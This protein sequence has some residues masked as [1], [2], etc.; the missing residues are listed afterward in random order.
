MNIFNKAKK[1]FFNL[2]L[3]VISVYS[4]SSSESEQFGVKLQDGWMMDKWSKKNGV[5]CWQIPA[6]LDWS[7][8]QSFQN[9]IKNQSLTST[10]EYSTT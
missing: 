8:F 9:E 10:P 7:R 6:A 2:C 3:K 5:L 4:E 1:K